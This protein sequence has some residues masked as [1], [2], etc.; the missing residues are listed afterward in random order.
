MKNYQ[1]SILLSVGILAVV[2]LAYFVF[3][4]GKDKHD[5]TETYTQNE[6]D[7]YDVYVISEMLKSYFPKNKFKSL[8]YESED[9]LP[10]DPDNVSSYVFIGN[11]PYYDSLEIEELLSFVANGNEAFISSVSLPRNLVVELYARDCA[12]LDVFYSEEEEDYTFDHPNYWSGYS[13][14]H[15]KDIEARFSHPEL[16][17]ENGYQFK[18]RYKDKERKYF[19]KFIDEYTFCSDAIDYDILGRIG[20]D[21][22]N[23]IRVAHGNGHFLIHTN[24]LVFTNFQ[25]IN[26]EGLE[27]AGKVFSHLPEGDIYWDEANKTPDL[28]DFNP[29][30]TFSQG[31]LQYILSQKSLRWAWYTGLI[32]VLLYVLFR[33]KRRQRIIPVLPENTNTSLEY[34]KTIGRLYF[35]QNEH[36]KLAHQEMKLFLYYLR[37]HYNI[38]TQNLDE[39]FV[40][41]VAIKSEVPKEEIKKIIKTWKKIEKSPSISEHT[42]IFFHGKVDDFYR[43]SK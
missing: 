41:K 21:S 24:P 32:L 29:P 10:S 43:N 36:K 12:D 1:R 6:R 17:T 31:P 7:P 42:L 11:V 27:Y 34:I 16:K 40:D 19:W 30:R 18:H 2:A 20:L 5:W 23:Y 3:T 22:L 15:N 25:M 9:R 14:Y 33:A 26:P 4:N 13:S 8:K 39:N 38:P 28:P 35:Q 37:E